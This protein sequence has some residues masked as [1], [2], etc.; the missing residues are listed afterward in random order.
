MRWSHEIK[1]ARFAPLNVLETGHR[2]CGVLTQILTQSHFVC[3]L[4]IQYQIV[5]IRQIRLKILCPQGR[6]GSSPTTRT[7]FSFRRSKPP[8]KSCPHCLP[9][10]ASFL[11]RLRFLIALRI[12][13]PV[14]ACAIDVQSGTISRRKNLVKYIEHY[15]PC[16][17]FT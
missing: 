14:C 11:I 12:V 17:A 2:N 13:L 10:E 16:C 15:Q 9:D 4:C 6:V 1:M 3:Q 7:I 8:C 5:K